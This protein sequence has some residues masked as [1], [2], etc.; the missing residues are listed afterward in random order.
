MTA[1]GDHADR[2]EQSAQLGRLIDKD[3]SDVYLL[4]RNLGAEDAKATVGRLLADPVS[5]DATQTGLRYLDDQ[6]GTRRADGVEMAIRALAAGQREEGRIRSVC[7]T[8]M[9]SLVA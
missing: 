1:L 6:F 2:L 9:D 5:A 3:A 4:M 8:F 7:T